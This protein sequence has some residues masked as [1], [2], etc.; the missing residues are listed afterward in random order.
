MKRILVTGGAGYIGSHTCL[1]L[2][3]KGFEVVVIDNFCNSSIES[4]QRVEKLCGKGLSVHN[5]DLMDLAALEQTIAK[6]Y[7]NCTAVLFSETSNDTILNKD[8]PGIETANI[9]SFVSHHSCS[10]A[11]RCTR[12]R[13]FCQ[14]RSRRCCASPASSSAS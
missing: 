1:S 11:R 13:R 3:E 4:L 9:I 12:Y 5:V 14:R 6:E 10:P 8:Y 7:Q 2:L